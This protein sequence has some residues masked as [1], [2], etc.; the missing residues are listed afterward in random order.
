MTALAIY[1]AVT[2]LA[3]PLARLVLW[4]RAARGKE[5]PARLPERRGL[6]SLP[7]PESPLL[8]LHAAS[9]GEAQSVLSL[10][11]RLLAM[12]ADLSI[13][14]TSGTVTSATLLQRRLPERAVHQYSPADLPGWVGAFLDHWRPDLAVFVESELWPNLIQ[15]TAARACPLVLVNGRLSARSFAKWRKAPAA[16][17][18]LLR[19]FALC[20]GQTER[21]RER[22]SALGAPHAE[23]LGN[24]KY[25]AA[26]LPADEAEL[27]KLKEAVADRPLWLAAST[28][29]GEEELVAQV[30]KKLREIHPAILTVV[31]P[32]H[33]DRGDEIAALFESHGLSMGRRSTGALPESRQAVY[34]ADTLGELGLFYRLAE[35]AFIGGSTGSLGGHN[36]LEAAQLSCAIL[37]G[38]DMTNFSTVDADLKAAEAAIEIASPAD[39]ANAVDRLLSDPAERQRLANAAARVTAANASALDNV[40]TALTPFVEALPAEPAGGR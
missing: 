12:R 17:R 5:D 28:H 34:L 40:V 39:L 26:A 18:A 21:D 16:A 25:S 22:L 30:H 8:W 4:R 38:P 32:R 33:P 10:I 1:R 2:R 9:V 14:V 19:C 20:L 15:A 35:I 13:L 11:G 29:P 6:A 7:R 36:P 31:V 27:G 24:L 3:G 37:H 23:Y